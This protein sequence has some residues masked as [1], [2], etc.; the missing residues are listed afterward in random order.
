M[1]SRMTVAGALRL[2][3]IDSLRAS[4]DGRVLAVS[5]RGAR[6]VLAC[7]ALT[8]G[9]EETRARLVSLIWPN[10]DEAGGRRNLRQTLFQLRGELSAAGYDGL[11]ADRE[12][13]ALAGALRT[14]VAELLS[15]L[16]SGVVPPVLLAGESLAERILARFTVPGDVFE[17]WLY[18]RRRQIE[19]ELRTRLSAALEAAAPGARRDLARAL[20][21]LDPSDEVAA[22]ALI[23]AHLEAGDVGSALQTYDRLWRHLE[24]EFDTEPAGETQA[25]V[26]AIKM[27]DY[28]PAASEEGPGGPPRPETAAPK[29][30][31]V[32][33][34]E[35]PP[36][37]VAADEPRAFPEISVGSFDTTG[38]AEAC[39]PLVAL[40]RRELISRL[41]RFREWR[42]FDDPEDGRA[43]RTYALRA[44]A[45]EVGPRIAATVALTGTATGEVIW[46]ERSESLRTRWIAFQGD[47]AGRMAATLNLNLSRARLARLTGR[48]NPA[49][50][51]IDR[52]LLGQQLAL[53]FDPAGW[54]RAAELF[55]AILADW[56]DFTRAYTSLAQLHNI[57][58]IV[59]PG[60]RRDPALFAE[61]LLLANRAIDLDPMDSQTHLSR[62]WA[63]TMAQRYD[64][65][66]LAFGLAQ[67]TNPNDAWVVI[68]SALGLAFGG[69][70]AVARNLAAQ[71]ISLGWTISP[72]DWCYHATIRFLCG[73]Y[74]GCVAAARNG[75]EAIRNIPG[76]EAAALTR[77]GR[78]AEAA[79]AYTRFVELARANWA[80]ER[81]AEEDSILA[82]VTSA[83]PIR[84]PAVRAAFADGLARAR[85][86]AS[87]D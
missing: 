71:S 53:S 36:D 6:A 26:V 13:V 23:S 2:T 28:R 49:A 14:D 34:P 83:F 82:W 81:A 65:A 3:L 80:G 75:G 48:D 33:A 55:R 21:I 11:E 66:E 1:S 57:R 20:V 69:R 43:E 38:L 29:M 61:A 44:S 16:A 68:S 31:A 4:V 12:K 50:D 22:R 64:E 46:T 73:D 30:P 58:N 27:G 74:D 59:F 18:L 37:P 40:F 85:Y 67:E 78:S 60:T 41:A 32:A 5:S 87:D 77:L 54:T 70:T 15:A 72:R 52:W 39:R 42:I 51:A 79:R 76:W 17:S 63:L 56:P 25:L 45:V 8:P 19:D 10:H 24:R 35:H 86:L 84:D 7:L 62:G 9:H 47:L